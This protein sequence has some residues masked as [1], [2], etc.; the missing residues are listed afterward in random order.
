[1]L[2]N[3]SFGGVSPFWLRMRPRAWPI[4]LRSAAE[5]DP[6]ARERRILA[7]TSARLEQHEVHAQAF[8]AVQR[9]RPVARENALRQVVAAA[10]Y[11]APQRLDVPHLVLCGLG[12]QLVNPECSRAIAERWGGQLGV[13]PSGGHD[14]TLDEPEWVVQRVLAWRRAR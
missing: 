3:S 7:L 13:H 9:L 4:V 11:R 1:V 5:R 10:R 14:L 6:E 12:D 2:V 8:A